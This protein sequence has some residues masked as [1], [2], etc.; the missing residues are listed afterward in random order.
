MTHPKSFERPVHKGILVLDYGSQYTLLIARR[1]REVGSYSEIVDGRASAPPAG[2]EVKGIIL[3]GGPDSVYEAG[4][5]S[6]PAW[7]MG[8][9]VP[10]LGICYGMQL[11]V[12]TAGGKVR[13]G[14]KREYGK[15]VMHPKR[16]GSPASL[17]FDGTQPQTVWMSHGDDIGEIPASYELAGETDDHVVAA[18]THKTLPIAGLQYHPEVA[19]S[20]QGK[21]LLG[22]RMRFKQVSEVQN[23][24]L[25]GNR[26]TAQRKTCKSAHGGHLVEG[27]FHCRITQSVPLLHAVHPDHRRQC[28]SRST[29]SRLR[30]HRL[31]KIDHRIPRHHGIHLGKK[32]LPL[33]LLALGSVFHIGETQLAHDIP[34]KSQYGLD[35][36]KGLM[37]DNHESFSEVP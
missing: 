36:A 25:I 17:L 5:R 8:L 3:S 32:D 10:V 21:E 35:H 31:N 26:A 27:F 2:F 18:I 7:V 22:Q 16:I 34:L 6:L 14:T 37:F 28:V 9:K 12:E 30:I 4:S 33:G 23:R 24:R 29:H 15:A 11:L 1:L 13:A 20:D 19:H